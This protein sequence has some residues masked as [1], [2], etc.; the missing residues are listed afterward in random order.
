MAKISTKT[1][2]P[3]AGVSLPGW[4]LESYRSTSSDLANVVDSL[5][6][7]YNKQQDR[8]AAL[9]LEAFEM[10]QKQNNFEAQMAYEKENAEKNR[11]LSIEKEDNLF[12]YV[13]RK[14]SKFHK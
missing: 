7:A 5:T 11:L 4:A 6:D 1:F 14:F 2:N 3:M 10:N 12:L 9:G 8:E 13:S